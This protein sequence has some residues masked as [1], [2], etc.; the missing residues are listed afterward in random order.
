MKYILT[1]CKAIAKLKTYKV[2]N[3]IQPVIKTAERKRM[4]LNI[5]NCALCMCTLS[6]NSP[7]C[8]TRLFKEDLLIRSVTGSPLKNN[9][10]NKTTFI[11]T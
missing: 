1:S 11:A 6:F 3:V 5:Y 2:K 8:L 9:D 10:I 7:L 4:E